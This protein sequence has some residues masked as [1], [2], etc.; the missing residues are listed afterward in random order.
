MS[1]ESQLPRLAF[2]LASRV[3]SDWS[4]TFD[5]PSGLLYH[6][7]SAAGLLGIVPPDRLVTFRATHHRFLNDPDEG[8]LIDGIITEAAEE[9]RK[10]M[11]PEDATWD[12]ARQRALAGVSGISRLV[13]YRTWYVVSFTELRDDLTQWRLYGGDGAGYALAVRAGAID[14]QV[15]PPAAQGFLVRVVYRRR[16]QVEL[17]TAALHDALRLLRDPAIRAFAES[18]IDLNDLVGAALRYFVAEARELF[19]AMFKRE[20][21][22]LEREWRCVI[23]APD[24]ARLQDIEGLTAAEEAQLRRVQFRD[25]NSIPVPY[26][27]VPIHAAPLAIAEVWSGPALGRDLVA[28]AIPAFLRARGWRGNLDAVWQASAHGYRGRR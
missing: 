17:V 4:P 27:E 7:T 12:A 28:H 18:G 21:F 22:G 23:V 3:W 24:P 13:F 9:A 26:V 11:Q 5:P 10:A 16:Q 1:E 19:S 25:G 15:R 6:Y 14:A 8:A 20:Q 2:E